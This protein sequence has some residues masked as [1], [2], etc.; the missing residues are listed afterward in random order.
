MVY[1]I[2]RQWFIGGD[3]GCRQKPDGAMACKKQFL[4]FGARIW[5]G[6]FRSEDGLKPGWIR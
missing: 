1:P 6:F 4:I 2:D 3:V 5:V